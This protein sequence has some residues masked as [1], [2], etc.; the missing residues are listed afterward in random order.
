LTTGISDMARYTIAICKGSALLEETRALLRTWNGTES[1]KEL[2]QRVLHEDLLGRMTAY[3][4]RDIVNRVFARRYFR[5]D[6]RPAILL[7]RLL[8]QNQSGQL[9]SDLCFLYAARADDLIRDVVT[10]LYWPALS[11]GRLT[12]SP[13]YV[14]EFLRQAER[15]GKISEPWSEQVKLKVA[16]GVLKAIADFGLLVEMGRSRRELVHFR[17]TDRT[18]VFLAYDLHLTG[19]TDAGVVDHSDW[20]LFG[21][22]N[23]DVATAFDRLSGEGWW[24]AQVAGSVVRISWKYS[25]MEEV[26]DAITR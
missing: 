18:I 26:V 2:S 20:A 14:V 10:K 21:F 6:Q 24:I 9:F 4:A 12:L 1:A 16:R 5:P 19:F 25:S 15:E 17:P 7:K 23:K 22:N 13:E 3:R 8:A 11:N